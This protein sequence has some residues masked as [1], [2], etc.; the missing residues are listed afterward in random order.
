M[1]NS[2]TSWDLLREI[3]KK[4]QE[5]VNDLR[6]MYSKYNPPTEMVDLHARI[7]ACLEKEKE[8]QELLQSAKCI[9]DRGGKDTE[10]CS[11]SASLQAIGISGITARTYRSFDS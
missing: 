7:S 6:A 3:V 5:A 1:T 8:T 2:N 11:F 9:A 10:W 4:D